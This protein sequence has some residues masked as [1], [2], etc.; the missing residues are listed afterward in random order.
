[1]PVVFLTAYYGLVDLGGLRA[2][3]SVLVH[4]AA[5]GVGM[6]AVQLARHLGAEVFGTASAGKWDTL[7]S[8]GLDDRH[9][10]SSRELGFARTVP[11]RRRGAELAGREFVDAS[12]GLL[13]PGGRFLEMGKTDL[14]DPAE[15]ALAHPG[16]DYRIYDIM[17]AGPDRIGEMLAELMA[18][19]RTGAL[20]PLPVTTWDVRRAA[21][22]LRFLSQARHVGKVVLT[23][24]RAIDPAGT[25]LITGATGVLGGAVARHLVAEHGVRKL[26]LA[27]RRGAAPELA[28]ELTELGA[29][30]DVVRCD[31]ADRTALAAVLDAIPRLTAVIHAAGVLDDATIDALTP[32]QLDTVLRPK[33]DAARN[34]HEL[35]GDVDAFVLFSSA[36]ATLGAPGQGNY[37]AANAFLDGLAERRRAAGL[38]GQSLGWGLWAERSAMTAHLG[39]A[40]VRRMARAGPDPAVHDG[41]S[42]AVRRGAARGRAARAADAPGHRRCC[43]GPA[44]C[45]RCSAAW[46]APRCGARRAAGARRPALVGRLARMSAAERE[47]ALLDLVR[48]E[49]ATVLGH[50]SP[51]TIEATRPFK[52][53]GF[54]SLTAVELRNRLA[55]AT[56]THAAGDAGVRLPDPG[57]GGRPPA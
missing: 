54:D 40:D 31:V 42:G 38:A 7:R 22:A 18:L 37:A 1:M 3:E 41:R 14:R 4:A 53:V 30:V 9:I 19:F 13:A 36:S 2:G 5:G 20:R 10:A 11:R 16:V 35:A 8:L 28:A 27:G 49:V 15:V 39:E 51:E 43:A 25:V 34:L 50:S 56:G 17:E 47:R 57:R 6:A 21:A 33:V 48:A 44:R 24:P 29:T 23:M 52:D 55:A 12:L 46:S 26:V 45:P 32:E